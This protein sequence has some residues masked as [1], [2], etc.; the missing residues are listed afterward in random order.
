MCSR[1]T[2]IQQLLVIHKGAWVNSRRHHFNTGN[3]K[4]YLGPRYFFARKQWSMKPIDWDTTTYIFFPSLPLADTIWTIWTLWLRTINP[5][6]RLICE[7]LGSFIIPK[8]QM[9]RETIEYSRSINAHMFAWGPNLNKK[10]LLC[11]FFL[12]YLHAH[13]ML[14]N[15]NVFLKMFPLLFTF[16]TSDHV[17]KLPFADCLLHI[18]HCDKLETGTH[19]IT[20]PPWNRY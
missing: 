14:K 9:Q 18:I 8:G 4:K 13:T 2:E 11:I 17:I 12:I 20:P 19:P 1:A 10:K 16:L 7:Y 6:V 3:F 15:I 5:P